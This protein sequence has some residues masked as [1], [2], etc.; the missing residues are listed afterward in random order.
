[1]GAQGVYAVAEGPGTLL[2]PALALA[3][4]APCTWI[5]QHVFVG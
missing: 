4:T 5:Y 1:M 2:F 3:L